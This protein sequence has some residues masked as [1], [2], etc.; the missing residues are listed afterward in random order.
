M[1]YRERLNHWAV[2]R[3]LPNCQRVVIDRFRSWSDA[4]GHAQ[5]MRR[6][7]PDGEFIVVFDPVRAD[8]KEG[9]RGSG[10]GA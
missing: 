3:L 7:V 4:E 2:I 1:T 10:V 8:L 5:A 9:D 6:L